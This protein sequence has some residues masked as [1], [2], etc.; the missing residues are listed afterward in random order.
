MPSYTPYSRYRRSYRAAYRRPYRARRGMPSSAPTY[1]QIFGKVARDV[2]YLKSLVNSELKHKS[3]S[4]TTAVST[5][6]EIINLAAISQGDTGTTRDGS[7]V[8]LRGVVINGHVSMSASAT[9][10]Q[11]RMV[12]FVWKRVNEVAPTVADVLVSSSTT[13]LY[14]FN[15]RENIEILWDKV[16]DLN[17]TAEQKISFKKTL[18]LNLKQHYKGADAGGD[19]ADLMQNG[20]GLLLIS[21]EATNT[22]TPN[23]HYR[24]F[25]RDN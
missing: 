1:G 12:V 24:V 17:I 6:G 3:A 10:T 8:R 15:N 19:W 20:L 11:F 21:D 4:T 22:P 16:I 25:F 7:Y 9:R 23:I 18:K 2:S 14:D 13:S 5:T